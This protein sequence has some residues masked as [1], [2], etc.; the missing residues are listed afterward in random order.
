VPYLV[1]ALIEFIAY[2]ERYW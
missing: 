1:K 2:S